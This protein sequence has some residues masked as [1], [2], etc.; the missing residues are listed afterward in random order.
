VR[1][2]QL[3]NSKT[4]S[5]LNQVNEDVVSQTRLIIIIII[6]VV[7]VVVVVISSSTVN[8]RSHSLG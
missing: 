1:R 3:A 4:V 6:I 7:V 2:Q 8:D 5:V